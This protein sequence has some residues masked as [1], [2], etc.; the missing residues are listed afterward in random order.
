M[1]NM[2]AY[3]NDEDKDKVLGCHKLMEATGEI[4]S[5]GQIENQAVFTEQPHLPLMTT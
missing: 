1:Y 3:T 5:Y 2:S 4:S